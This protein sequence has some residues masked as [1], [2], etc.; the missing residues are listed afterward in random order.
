M[1]QIIFYSKTG[2]PWCV[3]MKEFLDNKGYKYQEKNVTEDSELF[4]ELKT[5]SGQDKA[6]TLIIDGKIHADV[7]VDDIKDLL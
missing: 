6:P 5:L 2:C 7:G 4:V 1:K 3:A